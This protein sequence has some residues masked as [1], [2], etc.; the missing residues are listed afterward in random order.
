MPVNTVL[1]FESMIDQKSFWKKESID[2]VFISALDFGLHGM[3]SIIIYFSINSILLSIMSLHG[4]S[5]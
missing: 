5:V 3:I 2:T 1:D 4:I